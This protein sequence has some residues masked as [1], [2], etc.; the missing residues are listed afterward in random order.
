VRYLLPI[1]VG[2]VAV[3]ATI[4]S[5]GLSWSHDTCCVDG[6]IGSLSD[7]SVSEHSRGGGTRCCAAFLLSAKLFRAGT[8]DGLV[9]ISNSFL[10]Q[11]PAEAG[12]IGAPFPFLNLAGSR[13]WSIRRGSAE[14]KRGRFGS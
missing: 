13:T 4:R 1:T 5:A 7:E 12:L 10:V 9:L 14:R 6:E 8:L 3:I 11:W 2:I